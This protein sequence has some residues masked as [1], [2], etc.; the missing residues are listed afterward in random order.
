M[1]CAET[2]HKGYALIKVAIITDGISLTKWQLDALKYAYDLLDVRLVLS[3]RNT[4][5]KKAWV[6]NFFYFVLNFLTLRNEQTRNFKHEFQGVDVINFDSLYEGA[7]QKLPDCIV[8]RLKS[9][10]IDVVVKFGMSLLRIDGVLND[11]DILSFH[12]GDPTE[13]RGAPQGFTSCFIKRKK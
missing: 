4:K 9:E 6:K 7:W 3:C 8:D 11:I 13:Y 1:G 10:N 12:H 5:T 2:V